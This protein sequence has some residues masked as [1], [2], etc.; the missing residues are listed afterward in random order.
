MFLIVSKYLVPKGYRGMTVY[1]F[2]I[3]RDRA[4]VANAIL[5]N[6]EKIHIR[7]QAELLVVGFYIGYLCSYFIG[8]L[9]FGN[10]TKAYRNI[11]FEREAYVNENDFSYL[12]K[13]PF[14]NFLKF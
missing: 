11:I 10:H 12:K 13:R 6:H 2:I 14:W 8:L 4:E 3:L 7:Q 5:L 9:K 1:P